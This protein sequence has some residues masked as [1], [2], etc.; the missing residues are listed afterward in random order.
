MSGLDPV[1]HFFLSISATWSVG[2][3]NGTLVS[4]RNV[5]A[6]AFAANPLD[7]MV[8]TASS[9]ILAMPLI[10][11]ISSIQLNS[12][13]SCPPSPLARR[14]ILVRTTIGY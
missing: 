10:S 13:H 1:L 8:L 14:R 6:G 2:G 7:M 3:R 9:S 12:F 4:F 11:G 5:R